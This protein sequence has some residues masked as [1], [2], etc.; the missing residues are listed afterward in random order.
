MVVL[1][2]RYI[3]KGVA[4]LVKYIDKCLDAGG[5][6]I[7]VTRYAGARIRGPDGTPAVVVRCF[8]RREQVPGGVI[9]GLPEDVIKKAEEF[10]GD[11]KW[12]LAEYGH[13]VED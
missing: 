9:Y 6:P 5:F 11:W 7:V 8:G 3:G 12:I 1:N 13:L 4:E 2:T 10:V